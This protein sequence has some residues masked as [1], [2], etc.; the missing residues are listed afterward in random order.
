MLATTIY[1]PQS[2]GLAL[3]EPVVTI[4]PVTTTPT[5]STSATPATTVP[6][7]TCEGI[8]ISEL[9]PNPAGT[10]T[11]HE[12]IELHNP[13]NE[14]INLKGCDLQSTA[15]TT[16]TYTFG[17]LSLQ[18]GEYRS[19]SD[20]TTG[21]SLPNSSGG[22]AWL[23]SPTDELQ[24]ITYPAN[25]EDDTSWAVSGS[26]WAT[27]YTPTPGAAN[28]VTPLKP[29]D[30]PTQVRS[31]DTGR[32][33]TP[34]SDATTS[35]TTAAA[36][37]GTASAPTPC[38]EGQERNPATNRCRNIATATAATQSACKAGQ[39]RNPDT[40][41]C[42]NIASSGTTAKECPTGQVRNPDTSRCKKATTSATSSAGIKSVKDMATSNTASHGKPY[43][44]I[45][46]IVIIGAIA[47]A[48]YEWHQEIS[49]FISRRYG[50]KF[51]KV[52]F[53]RNTLLARAA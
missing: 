15:S 3:P 17:D 43:G 6:S 49:L 14:V 5:T 51:A 42:R 35:S 25:M 46:V 11:G 12:F 38:K 36:T 48:I 30:D 19:F 52:P 50:H 18:P 16:K 47:Y 41:R 31:A 45:A 53:L 7:V 33:S 29:C 1:T 23:L 21:I 10:D 24:A 26:T 44:L 27:S 4:P 22:T 40:N 2:V 28:V 37:S 20:A 32:C 8:V 13:T 34:T 39:E 9:L